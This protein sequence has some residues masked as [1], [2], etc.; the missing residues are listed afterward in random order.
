MQPAYISIYFP[1][2]DEDLLTENPIF[3]GIPGHFRA[4]VFVHTDT[5][6]SGLS[7]ST[8]LRASLLPLTLG[9][10]PAASSISSPP[11]HF[12][13]ITAIAVFGLL[14]SGVTGI[15]KFRPNA[16]L[17]QHP[18]YVLQI[19]QTELQRERGIVVF[20]ENRGHIV[21]HDEAVCRTALH[22]LSPDVR[23]IGRGEGLTSAARQVR[24][25]VLRA[26]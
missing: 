22:D 23:P 5:R 8:S 16:S 9:A 20:G 15:G 1:S 2:S 10:T 18:P 25:L 6:L 17:L 11:R 24:K 26:C 13:G 21:L 4:F 7:S 14:E 3:S 19:L 12:S